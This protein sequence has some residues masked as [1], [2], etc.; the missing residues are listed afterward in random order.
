M[1]EWRLTYGFLAIGENKHAAI[2]D[3]L[4]HQLEQAA[5]LGVRLSHLNGET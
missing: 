3:V 2:R 1:E 4:A 5:E